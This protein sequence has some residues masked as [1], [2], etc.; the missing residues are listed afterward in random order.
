[1]VA[2]SIIHNG[3]YSVFNLSLSCKS[4]SASSFAQSA[5][6]RDFRF[7]V[8]KKMPGVEFFAG[9]PNRYSENIESKKFS[10][11]NGIPTEKIS[12]SN[13]DNA[14]V[15]KS[16][17]DE[18]VFSES[19]LRHVRQRLNALLTANA[20]AQM[21]FCTLTFNNENL[22]ENFRALQ[23]KMVLFER[24]LMRFWESNGFQS[25][26]KSKAPCVLWIP[27]LGGKKGRLHVHAIIIMPF[28][29]TKDF[30]RKIWKYGFCDI[31]SLRT[32][33]KADISKQISAYVMK[34]VTKDVQ[35]IA[36]RSRVYYATKNWRG[37]KLVAQL[38]QFQAEK[39]FKQFKFLSSQEIIPAPFITM[40]NFDKTKVD[41]M[42]RVAF[43]ARCSFPSFHEIIPA[44]YISFQWR[45]PA[46]ESSRLM[47][48]FE[49]L[50]VDFEKRGILGKTQEQ[51]DREARRKLQN[52]VFEECMYD[53]SKVLQWLPKMQKAF[54][55]VNAGYI[56]GI[57]NYMYEKQTAC[58]E[59]CNFDLLEKFHSRVDVVAG[60]YPRFLRR[61]LQI[62]LGADSKVLASI[63]PKFFRK[64]RYSEGFSE[65]AKN[66]Y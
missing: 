39:I 59:I 12:Q 42:E 60:K 11:P 24:R 49:T 40:C 10:L 16:N 20:S 6:N 29:K 8:H 9:L 46:S 52:K 21:K 48:F 63:L 37:E 25:A 41:E 45:V 18:K 28:I 56:Y 14:S 3:F 55:N 64:F 53:K 54:P 62:H 35:R 15:A 47:S 44:D 43:I 61:Q 58:A 23:K 13:R 4:S 7:S 57:L 1:M 17:A 33:A 26:K 2:L 31:K 36:G 51:R 5:Y 34:Y 50:Y 30:A 32:S 38:S 22:P 65:S 66:K 19:T 27:E